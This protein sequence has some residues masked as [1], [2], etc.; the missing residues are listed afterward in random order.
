MGDR[1][2]LAFCKEWGRLFQGFDAGARVGHHVHGTDTCHLIHPHDIPAGKKATY[3]RI[4]AD[5]REQKADPYRVRCTVGGNLIDFPGDKST[6]AADLV[7]VKCLI[8]NVIS[9]PG[10]RAACIDIK[11][12][13]L[14]NTLPEA[15][16]VRFRADSIPDTIWK[17]YTLEDYNTK[18]DYVYAKVMKGMYGL[19]QAGKVASDHLIPRLKAAGYLE[20][21]HTPGL[22]K[23]QT[24]SIIF[25]LVVDDFFIQYSSMDDFTHLTDTLQQHYTITTDMEAKKFCGITLDWN[26]KDGHVTLSM[27]GYV[28]KALHRF[29]HPTPIRPQHAPHPWIP[30]NYGATVQYAT[31]DDISPLLDT[32][33][34]KRLQEVIGT[35]LF[36]GRA[37]DNTMLAAL[38]TLATA[39]TCGTE[40]TM[41]NLVQ[42]LDY[43]ATHPNAKIRFHSSDMILYV[44]SDASYLSEPKARS[45]VGGYFYLG[46]TNQPSDIPNPNGPIH[47]ESR[48]M[49]NVMAA[50]SEAEIGALFHNGQEATHMRNI[51]KEMGREQTEP[52]RITTDN[53]TA[54]G[55]ANKRT[56]IKRSKAMDMR[57]YWVQDRVEQGQFRIHWQSG[58]DNHADYFTKH[59]PASHHQR[60]RSIYLHTDHSE[61]SPS[62]HSHTH[63]CRGVLIP[64]PGSRASPE[65]ES[66]LASRLAPADQ[67]TFPDPQSLLSH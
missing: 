27:P 45:R 12:F 6:K 57:F 62:A 8:N 48:I 3:I 26:Y 11:D 56:K 55:F 4:V 20:T 40:Q 59:H 53:S 63:D 28:E 30:P 24:N 65:C 16:Y 7:T 31:P 18:D 35:F 17:Q 36:Y 38:G 13:Y 54:D 1:W 37:V 49:K 60:V 67:R 21:G 33:S 46:D 22:F 42:L 9:T 39:Q 52:T 64:Q 25:A 5:Y 19:P 23:H 14:N 61:Q 66:C 34:T 50:A 15:E 47:V 2:Q 51:L 44:H 58:A 29:T 41:D 10:A 43:A 32:T